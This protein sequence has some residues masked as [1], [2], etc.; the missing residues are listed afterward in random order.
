MPP[1]AV[2]HPPLLQQVPLGQGVGGPGDRPPVEARSPGDGVAVQAA[3]E[4]PPVGGGDNAQ[5]AQ[6]PEVL[7]AAWVPGV[8]EKVGVQGQDQEHLELAAG[9]LG[10]QAR[11]GQV[12]V[13]LGKGASATGG[14]RLRVIHGLGCGWLG[15]LCTW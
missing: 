6:A 9:Q 4:A 12:A 1:P 13:D 11:R 10:E 2:A 8:A 15:R 14:R 3:E 7:L 5:L